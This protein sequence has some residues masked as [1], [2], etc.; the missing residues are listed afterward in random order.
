MESLIEKVRRTRLQEEA[1][2]VGVRDRVEVIGR[3]DENRSRVR[4][5]GLRELRRES[6]LVDEGV[7]DCLRRHADGEPSCGRRGKRRD[8][9][10]PRVA[11]G[12]QN[13]AFQR[14]LLEGA[15]ELAGLDS[16]RDV[17]VQ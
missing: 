10:T 17:A 14:E 16:R 4:H 9:L 13:G 6:P 3:I 12:G 2:E 1:R 11:A 8:G 5:G 7:D 15:D